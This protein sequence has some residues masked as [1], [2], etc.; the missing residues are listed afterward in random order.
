MTYSR[1]LSDL[2]FVAL[3]NDVLAA[4]DELDEARSRVR[5]AIGQPDDRRAHHLAFR[6]YAEAMYA[7]LSLRLQRAAEARV[8]DALNSGRMKP[9]NN[10]IE[11]GEQQEES[12]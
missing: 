2:E 11:I 12:A 8:R 4:E 10:G 3:A 6:A 7:E 9:A 1:L 5:T